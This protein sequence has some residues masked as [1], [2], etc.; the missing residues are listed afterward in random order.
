MASGPGTRCVRTKFLIGFGMQVERSTP[1]RAI[2]AQRTN[3]KAHWRRD[4]ARRIPEPPRRR[5]RCGQRRPRVAGEVQGRVR[6]QRRAADCLPGE[7]RALVA[8]QPSA[9]QPA[10]QRTDLR[11]SPVVATPSGRGAKRVSRR[12]VDDAPSFY[13]IEA[14]RRRPDGSIKQGSAGL[15]DPHQ[16]FAIKRKVSEAENHCRLLYDNLIAQG[17]APEQARSILP[18]SMMTEWIETGSLAYFARACGQRL[19][20]YAQAEV[21][22]LAERVGVILSPLFPV[23]WRVLVP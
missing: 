3:G 13:R 22:E 10:H 14:W 11:G 8:I 1:A 16:Q 4:H 7:A 19:D 6:R 12:Y 5:S 9:G 20:D 15:F 18:Q 17:V 2:L 23:S 21:R